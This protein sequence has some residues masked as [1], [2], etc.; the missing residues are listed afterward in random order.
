MVLHIV[1][2]VPMIKYLESKKQ[3]HLYPVP[4][5]KLP[6][7]RMLRC[8]HPLLLNQAINHACRSLRLLLISC[9][10]RWSNWLCAA[11][12]AEWCAI[13]KLERFPIIK[14]RFI[15][16]RH[17]GARSNSIFIFIGNVKLISPGARYKTY[18]DDDEYAYK[19][20][21]LFNHTSGYQ[22]VVNFKT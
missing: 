9:N 5:S 16:A 1:Y 4:S 13:E 12:Y 22:S 17:K 21:C 3:R 11:G 18:D 6:R 7:E 20:D 15:Q 14:D 10:R 8:I 2:E 19:T